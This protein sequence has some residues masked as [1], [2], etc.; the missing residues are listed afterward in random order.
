MK[1]IKR[2][3][4]MNKPNIIPLI[5]LSAKIIHTHVAIMPIANKSNNIIGMDYKV[6]SDDNN[7]IVYTKLYTQLLPNPTNPTKAVLTDNENISNSITNIYHST[8]NIHI[9]S[10]HDYINNNNTILIKKINLINKLN[11]LLDTIESIIIL[12]DNNSIH[13]I[14]IDALQMHKTDISK[15]ITS[16]IPNDKGLTK[17]QINFLNSVTSF[18]NNIT[19]KY[20]I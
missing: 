13:P 11:F 18:T 4:P 8:N 7:N 5:P 20:H 1:N 14:Y 2:H 19:K 3:A 15:I 17:S 9:S 6:I 16:I 12:S 10:L